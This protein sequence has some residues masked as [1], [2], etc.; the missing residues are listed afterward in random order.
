MR[1]SSKGIGPVTVLDILHDIGRLFPAVMDA[2]AKVDLV[3]KHDADRMMIW[4]I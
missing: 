2:E 1:Y 4:H 3:T